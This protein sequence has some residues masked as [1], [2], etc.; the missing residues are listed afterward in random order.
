MHYFNTV[1]YVVICV[2]FASLICLGFYLKKRASASL[3]D[4]FLGGRNLP[5]WALG[6]SGMAAW[7]DVTGTM[8]IT[9]FLFLLG[10]RGL[11]IEFRGGAVL[12]LPI[13]MLWTGK[14][15]RRSGCI[16]GAEWMVF[17]FGD[18]FGGQFARITSV[19]G[20][21]ASGI[22]MLAY[23]V[24]GVGLFLS[25][26]LPFHPIVC[27]AIL[28]G[29]A[30]LYTLA[31]GFYGVVFTDIFQSFI[32]L[33]MAIAIIAW[34]VTK[35]I[36][37]DLALL[38]EQVTGNQ[39][40]LSGA[41][42]WKTSMPAGYEVYRH[43]F[44]FTCFYL[45]RNLFAGLGAGAEPIYLGAR[46]DREC[47]TLS[48]LRA[49]C[50]TLRWP[51]MMSFAIMGLFL[52]H[53]L[54]KDQ[55]Q[56]SSATSVIHEYSGRISESQW[57]ATITSIINHPSHYPELVS[58][59]QTILGQDWAN[60]LTLVGFHGTVN[61]ER[62]L[63]AVILFNIPIGF[64]GMILVALI[65][66]SMSTFD[67]TVN[68]SMGF[69]TRDIYQRYLRPH[70]NQR[71]LMVA[72]WVFGL[73]LICSGFTLS[74]TVKNINDIWGWIIMGLMAGT[75]VPLVLRFYWWRFNGEGFAL[76]TVFGLLAAVIQRT[77]APS[78]S[79]ILQFLIMLCA[80]FTG[81]IIGTYIGKPT[82][83]SIL[84]HFYQ[85]TRPFGMWGPL[86]NTL[87][88]AAREQ[89][90]KEHK[91]DIMAL[92]F[93]LFWQITMFLWPMLLIVRNWFAFAVSFAIFCVCLIGM[94]FTWYRNL[95]A[96]DTQDK[97]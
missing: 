95:P 66:A 87:E 88:P 54:F 81:S 64:R 75:L 35:S 59:L 40:W 34:A 36:G 90:K 5:W 73:L 46:N 61:P 7:L 10:P 79:E 91:N 30:T 28:I 49:T 44:M 16:T 72:N 39:Q 43:L 80:G 84:E 25:M 38:A 24:K 65:A 60:K 50:I 58:R 68:M 70:A 62:V 74:Y 26:F 33:I 9:S 57:I 19:I 47:G 3:E 67:S 13:V 85:K 55:T 27:S 97:T 51:L 20:A 18:G 94:Y 77:V 31:S 29:V 17:R 48:F 53:D 69:F 86:V 56:L 11:F 22:G 83:I 82:E 8:I 32:V 23:M 92:P 15:H 1:D 37:V 78:L 52:V 93:V 4:Y 21:I 2:Y 96:S 14:W 42:H 6:I 45:M 12:I 89:I 76:G 41:P 63:P 71:E